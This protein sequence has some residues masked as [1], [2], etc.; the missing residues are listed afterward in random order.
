[1]NKVQKIL[2]FFIL[3]IAYGCGSGPVLVDAERYDALDLSAYQT[4]DFFQIDAEDTGT[5]EFAQNIAYLKEAIRQKMETYGLRQTSTNPDLKVNLG[6]V[7]EDKVQTRETNLATDPFLYIGQRSY[8]WKVE[9]IPVGTYKEGTL[10]MH[11]VDNPTGEAL[12]VGTIQRALPKKAK[13]TPGTIDDV[14]ELLFQ[15]MTKQ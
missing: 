7:V 13:N 8:S 14:V 9:E 3:A 4:F 1:M 15:K 10:T 12:W 11:V 6:I 5:P 2:S